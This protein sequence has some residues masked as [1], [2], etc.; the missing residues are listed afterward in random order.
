M[1]PLLKEPDVKSMYKNIVLHFVHITQSIVL[2]HQGRPRSFEHLSKIKEQEV[3]NGFYIFW[4]YNLD[5]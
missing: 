1:Q 2:E 3:I 5:D 4:R